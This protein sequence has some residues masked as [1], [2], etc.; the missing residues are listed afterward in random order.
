[1]WFADRYRLCLIPPEKPQSRK[2]NTNMNLF[3]HPSFPFCGKLHYRPLGRA[4]A[5]RTT[6]CVGSCVTQSSHCLGESGLDLTT[7]GTIESQTP[8]LHGILC[9]NTIYWYR[10]Y[11]VKN[12]VSTSRSRTCYSRC[13]EQAYVDVGV[14]W[15]VIILNVKYRQATLH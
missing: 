11:H 12:V 7:L 2:L 15:V 13:L 10:N 6:T 5:P 4:I 14:A 3:C 9:F 8:A 1:M